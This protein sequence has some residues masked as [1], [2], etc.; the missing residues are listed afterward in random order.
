MHTSPG[1]T[2]YSVRNVDSPISAFQLFMKNVILQYIQKWT[3]KEGARVHGQNWRD[4]TDSEL[5]KF[6]GLSNLSGVYK[7]RNESILQL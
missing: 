7:S 2:R 6:L 1:P 4:V 3:T 5:Q